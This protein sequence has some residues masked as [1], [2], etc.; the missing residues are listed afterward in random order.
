MGVS[1]PPWEAFAEGLRPETSDAEREPC[2]VGHGWQ[3]YAAQT[4]HEHHR[5]HVLWPRSSPDERTLCEIA[6]WPCCFRAI[7]GNASPSSVKDGF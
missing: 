3:N 1:I 4:V 6:K 7:H 2:Q 5:D